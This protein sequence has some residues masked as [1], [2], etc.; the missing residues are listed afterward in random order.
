MQ[1]LV[2]RQAPDGTEWSEVTDQDPKQEKSKEE[3]EADQQLLKMSQEIVAL[4]VS[5][6]AVEK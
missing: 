6:G 5:Y 2:I 3:E 1:L 4:L